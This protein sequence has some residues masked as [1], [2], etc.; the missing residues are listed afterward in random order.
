MSLLNGV[1]DS[2]D[3]FP[4]ASDPEHKTPDT[5]L[6][7]AIA[8]VQTLLEQ[9]YYTKELKLKRSPNRDSKKGADVQGTVTV[10]LRVVMGWLPNS[11]NT[12]HQVQVSEHHEGVRDADEK[13]PRAIGLLQAAKPE[14]WELSATQPAHAT[15]YGDNVGIRCR[16]C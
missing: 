9:P 13:T 16:R 11:I 5:F 6:G 1:F 3:K 8:N 4:T 10:C 14:C 15:W 12:V 2:L 7:E